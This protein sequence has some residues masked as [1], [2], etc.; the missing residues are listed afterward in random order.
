M[1]ITS[2]LRNKPSLD[3]SQNLES[4]YLSSRIERA[5]PQ[6][7]RTRKS[8]TVTLTPQMIEEL[9]GDRFDEFV[10]VYPKGVNLANHQ[11][12]H[13]RGPV[14]TSAPYKITDLYRPPMPN[15]DVDVNLARVPRP[16]MSYELVKQI[17]DYVHGRDNQYCKLD[18]CVKKA[19]DVLHAVIRPTA[20]FELEAPMPLGSASID[21][22]LAKKVVTAVCNA[23][24]ANIVEG[25]PTC[26]ESMVS[27]NENNS[28]IRQDQLRV[29]SISAVK[30]ST[31][32]TNF[33]REKHV[34]LKRNYPVSF[35]KVVNTSSSYA[36][37]QLPD[38]T[39]QK[40]KFKLKPTTNMYGAAPSGF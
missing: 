22:K 25:D 40:L 31:D 4:W 28:H 17:R 16:K 14:P 30:T 34:E 9:K 32:T 19:E 36:P 33:V 18:K 39:A 15:L 8:S 38:R 24:T 1:S 13:S 12:F 23:P 11:D 5:G 29:D 10:T 3:L 27:M 35:M 2:A 20:V 37:N 26:M 6:L 7:R 21:G